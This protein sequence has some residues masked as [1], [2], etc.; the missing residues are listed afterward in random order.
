MNEAV[1]ILS[2]QTIAPKI[3]MGIVKE[4]VRL[5]FF[6]PAYFAYSLLVSSIQ[7]VFQN[8]MKKRIT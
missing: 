6:F 2:T 4:K 1:K 3:N 8:K 5:C 7:S